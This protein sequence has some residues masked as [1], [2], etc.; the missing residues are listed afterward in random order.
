LR[1]L[2]ARESAALGLSGGGLAVVA[3]DPR[4]PAS[5]VLEEGDVLLALD[6]KPVTLARFKALGT[7]LARGDR[8]TLVIQRGGDRFV[9]QL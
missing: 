1:P 8:A 7:R 9:L 2:N 6:G 5:G 4:G 3:V